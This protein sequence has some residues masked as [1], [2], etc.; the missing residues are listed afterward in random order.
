MLYREAVFFELLFFAGGCS[1]EALA[2]DSAVCSPVRLKKD[3][4]EESIRTYSAR[5]ATLFRFWLQAARAAAR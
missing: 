2:F 3:E 1:R 4:D 5:C